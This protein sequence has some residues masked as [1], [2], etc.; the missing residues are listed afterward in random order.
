MPRIVTDAG[1]GTDTAS[2][3]GTISPVMKLALIAAPVLAL[4]SPIVPVLAF[5]TNRSPK[6]SSASPTGPR[7]PPV[8]SPVMKLAL[9][10][11]PL[12]ARY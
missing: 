5:P 12:L 1:S 10:A 8:D 9:T 2:N 11:V 7:P 3:E 6:P 4:Y